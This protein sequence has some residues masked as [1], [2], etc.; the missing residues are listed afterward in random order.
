MST[1]ETTGGA[2]D[3]SE[4]QLS[5]AAAQRRLAAVW[6][7]ASLLAIS[8]IFYQ[9]A[10]LQK[11]R[12]GEGNAAK[13]LSA[14][15]WQWLF[16]TL[17]PT[18]TAVVATLVVAELNHSVREVARRRRVGRFFFYVALG[19]SVVYLLAL[20]VMTCFTGMYSIPEDRLA[21]LNSQRFLFISLQS[22]VNAVFAV[23]FI[24]GRE[25]K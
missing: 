25:H 6:L 13:D 3:E 2:A 21:F 15:A 11:F 16:G 1:T 19:I 5:L 7:V 23:F 14:D 17:G 4:G 9:A 10:I 22:F 12:S 24:S 8:S 20:V 18:L